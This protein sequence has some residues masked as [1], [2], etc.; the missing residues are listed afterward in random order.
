MTP[1]NVAVEYF[2]SF[3]SRFVSTICSLSL[4]DSSHT[5][6]EEVRDSELEFMRAHYKS[7]PAVRAGLRK[8]SAE[9]MKGIEDPEELQSLA[10]T[11]FDL[12]H[13]LML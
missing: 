2:S 9:M 12:F 4:S 6:Y 7:D 3:T 1:E 13:K 8:R 11:F 10:Q 5:R